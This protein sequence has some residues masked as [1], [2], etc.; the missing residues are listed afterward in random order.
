M[1]VR[2]R[3]SLGAAMLA[4]GFGCAVLVSVSWGGGESSASS[5]SNARPAQSKVPVPGVLPAGSK[6]AKPATPGAVIAD[7]KPDTMKADELRRVALTKEFNLEPGLLD[8]R[9][10]L[11]DRAPADASVAPPT[12]EQGMNRRDFLRMKDKLEAKDNWMFVD[13]ESINKEREK[14][15]SDEA[16]K[17]KWEKKQDLK[18]REWWEYSGKDSSGS[19]NPQDI[20]DPSQLDDATKAQ[21]AR[22]LREQDPTGKEGS[23]STKAGALAKS[24]D[25]QY[26]ALSMKDLFQS[27][28]D[29]KT[30][31]GSDLGLSDLLGRDAYSSVSKEGLAQRRQ[32]FREFLNVSRVPKAAAPAPTESLPPVSPLTPSFGPAGF[33][34]PA[35]IGGQATPI[36]RDAFGAAPDIARGYGGAGFGN[37]RD[38]ARAPAGFG[39]RE[40]AN[41]SF[42]NLESSRNLITPSMMEPPKR[43]F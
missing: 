42:R 21:V 9:V 6:A 26:G 32:E 39:T 11:S 12:S 24:G 4:A 22:K 35:R 7:A 41:N 14:S 5:S 25:H 3:L 16:F 29:A 17:D 1:D 33:N 13:E 40:A 8:K 15:T 23:T 2:S 28:T 34:D 18:K 30:A 43:R 36:G 38:A 10:R 20:S 37:V 19:G 31:R 27:G